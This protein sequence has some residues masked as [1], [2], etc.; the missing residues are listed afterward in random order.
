[1]ST[2]RKLATA[3]ATAGLL[4]GIFGSTLAPVAQAK[5]LKAGLVQ[6]EIR[7]NVEDDI[8]AVYYGNTLVDTSLTGSDSAPFAIYSPEYNDG[9]GA[10]NNALCTYVDSTEIEAT[11]GNDLID[12]DDVSASVTT[13]GGLLVTGADQTGSYTGGWSSTA[14]DWGTSYS[15]ENVMDGVSF[16]VTANDDDTSVKL[17]VVT[18]KIN[19]QVAAT[20]NIQVIGPGKSISAV[21]RTGGW[22]AMNNNSIAKALQFT[23]K[24]AAGTSMW[25]PLVDATDYTVLDNGG[26]DNPIEIY[27]D[28]GYDSWYYYLQFYRDA[29]S[30]GDEEVTGDSV[31]YNAQYRRAD[32]DANFC[33]GDEDAIGSSHS[34]MAI[35]DRDDDYSG[36]LSAKDFKSN[37]ITIKCSAA[38]D[39]AVV[40]GIDFGAVTT[41]ELGGSTPLYVRIQDG[42]GNPMGLGSAET[43]DP[44]FNDGYIYNPY[45]EDD[46]AAFIPSPLHVDDS[47][48][49]DTD[50]ERWLVNHGANFEYEAT[51]DLNATCD[52]GTWEDGT[53]DGNA[54]TSGDDLTDYMKAGPDNAG[55]GN[56]IVC[57]YASNIMEDLGTN[58]VKL[59]LAYPYPSGLAGILGNSAV[60]FKAS[61]NVV[62]DMGATSAFGAALKVGKKTVSITGPV[63]AKVTFVVEDS[64]GNVK[65]Y[66][67]TVDAADKKAK[68][69]FKKAGTFD[70]YAMFGDNVTP[71]ARIKVLAKYL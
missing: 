14:S 8:Q 7:G 61:I 41:I 28:A 3:L 19:G 9:Q 4:A 34:V 25:L 56:V 60:T 39:E 26:G 5:T 23:F 63:G 10:I 65:T 45:T 31:D 44:G 18:V 69:V 54:P 49:Y 67:R 52:G 68:F 24:D 55:A 15:D 35:M 29:L 6:S 46:A 71:I 42:Y 33:D 22:V 27:W 1:M 57:Y 47:V 11:D 70:V 50:S 48:P 38:G 59:P 2:K 66:L 21:D 53:E 32:F 12:S 64:A 51:S 58:Y 13:S 40:T 17:S 43:I 30:S 36:E 16:C 37:V 62:R 20:L